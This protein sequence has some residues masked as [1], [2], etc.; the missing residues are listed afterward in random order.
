GTSVRQAEADEVLV[1]GVSLGA[2]MMVE[3]LARAFAADPDF[4]RRNERLAFL[5]V[6]S[7]LLK[8]GLHPAADGL[9]TAVAR[10]AGEPSLFWVEYQAKVDLINFYKT[11]PVAGMGLPATGKPLVRNV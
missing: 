4:C 3:A 10:V 8:I 5:T 9:K 7:S 1:S 6:G 11:D 2:V